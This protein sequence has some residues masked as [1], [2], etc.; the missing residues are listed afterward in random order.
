MKKTNDYILLLHRE[1]WVYFINNSILFPA[2]WSRN[3]FIIGRES[4]TAKGYRN[5]TKQLTVISHHM[6]QEIF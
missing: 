3:N 4:P 6:R 5:I 1:D 2:A